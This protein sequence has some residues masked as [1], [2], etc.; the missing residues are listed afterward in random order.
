MGCNNPR[1]PNFKK[2]KIINY[3]NQIITWNIKDLG[4]KPE[5]V[6]FKG[7]ATAVIGVEEARPPERLRKFIRGDPKEIAEKLLDILKKFT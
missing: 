1:F 2:K 4:L 5:E 3:E 6:G 7:S